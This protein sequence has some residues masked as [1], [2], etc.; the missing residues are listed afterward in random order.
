MPHMAVLITITFYVQE[1]KDAFEDSESLLK[2]LTPA[3][4]PF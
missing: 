4:W 1:W 2:L 3:V